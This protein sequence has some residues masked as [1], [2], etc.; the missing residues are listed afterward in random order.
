V[1]ASPR[2]S[3]ESPQELKAQEGIEWLAGL[4]RLSAATDRRPDQS[5]G[6]GAGI[7]GT[8][9]ATRWQE[10]P[11]KRQEGTG[12]R[13][14]GPAGQRGKPLKSESRTWLQDETSLQGAWRSKPSR[15][16][17]TLR[18]EPRRVWELVAEWTPRADVAKGKETLEEALGAL[19]QRAGRWQ[20]HSEEEVELRR[21]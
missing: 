6:V 18:A 3:K 1:R 7:S 13:R 12:R 21:G 2:W 16:C 20:Q 17:E 5:P 8:G 15:A 11:E 4:T 10:A 19:G 14:G 9:E